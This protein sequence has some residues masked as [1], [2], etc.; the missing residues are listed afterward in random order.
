M[1]ARTRLDER[2]IRVNEP[3]PCDCYDAHGV[4]LLKQGLVITSTRQVEFLI[5]RGLFALQPDIAGGLIEEGAGSAGSTPF[6]LLNDYNNRLKQIFKGLLQEMDRLPEDQ[7][8][9]ERILRLS[10]Q[11]KDLCDIDSDAI[12]GAIHLDSVGRYTIV[13]PV[14][15]AIV[16]ELLARRLN[17]ADEERRTIVAAA[18]TCDL[19]MIKL[20]E[21]LFRETE[22]LSPDQR[23]AVRIHPI[24]T[25]NLLRDLGVTDRVWL[26][27]VL[28]HHELQSGRG[29]PGGLAGI[30]VTVGARIVAM[31]DIYTAMITPRA[32]RKALLSKIDIR[33]VFLRRGTEIDA[34]LA[35]LFV[36]E[37]GIYPP[38]SFVQL[39]NGETAIVIRRGATPKTP[40]VKSVMG[41]RG[42]P[43]EKP[44]M[45]DSSAQEYEIHDVVA[46]DPIIRFSIHTLWDYTGT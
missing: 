7:G 21:R 40:T 33:D 37:I 13:H 45:R 38:G 43:F 22:S 6:Q 28:Q 24:D 9:V 15:R 18:L 5:D 41:P 12:I 2:Q 34:D 10:E 46:R 35:T 44:V 23:E 4:L 32:Y 19:G 14:Y 11:V 17:I 1:T 36:N 30:E 3:L 8:F 31:A 27:A 16:S 42:A 26:D 39:R 29:Y 25:A 20:Q